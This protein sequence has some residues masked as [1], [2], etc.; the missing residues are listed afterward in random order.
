MDLDSN[1]A[2][3]SYR[4]GWHSISA[5]TTFDP[6][7]IVT[8]PSGCSFTYADDNFDC[9]YPPPEYTCP[10]VSIDTEEG[11]YQIIVMAYSSSCA[12]DTAE[13]ELTINADWDGAEL[14][15]LVDDYD[16]YPYNEVEYAVNGCADIYAEDETAPGTPCVPEAHGLVGDEDPADDDPEDD[17]TD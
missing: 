8:N 14:T 4:T 7:F 10:S 5:D 6:W 17:D 12:G 15:N 13:Y 9:T 16:R 3:I 1:A 2:C 11:T